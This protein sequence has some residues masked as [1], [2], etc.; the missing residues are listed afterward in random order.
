MFISKTLFRLTEQFGIL[1]NVEKRAG[2][3]RS[4]FLTCGR[5]M[6]GLA[7]DNRHK[8]SIVTLF[9]IQA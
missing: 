3:S 7:A 6:K 5:I 4:V 1:K 8:P 9:W 2:V